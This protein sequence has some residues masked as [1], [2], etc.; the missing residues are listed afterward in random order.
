VQLQLFPWEDLSS[1]DRRKILIEI[2]NHY[3]H[4]RN[5]R[6]GRHGQARLRQAYRRVAAQK[7]RLLMAGVSRRE[8]LD[9]LHCCRKGCFPEPRK[10]IDCTA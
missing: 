7:K 1:D 10:C 9:F 5:L 3:W 4:I 6:G 8:L 2:R